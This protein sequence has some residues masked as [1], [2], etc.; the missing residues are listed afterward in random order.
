MTGMSGDE[1]GGEEGAKAGRR[2]NVFMD[3]MPF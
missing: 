1:T 3:E 2:E